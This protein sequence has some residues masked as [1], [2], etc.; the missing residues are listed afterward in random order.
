MNAARRRDVS[1][2]RTSA[3]GAPAA[4]VPT[5]GAPDPVSLDELLST[6]GLLVT[7]GPGGVGKT[8]TAAALAVTAAR[9]GRRVVVVTVDPARRLADALGIDAGSHEPVLVASVTDGSDVTG[10]ELWALMLDAERTFDDLIR[11]EAGDPDRAEA[12]LR[13]PVYRSITGALS[14]AQD[15]MAVER[16]HQ[17]H[18]DGAYDLV[19][20]DT[21]PSRHALDLLEAPDR[22]DGFLGHPVYRALTAPGRAFARVTNAASTA[23]LWTVRKLAGPS[24]VEDTLS[25]FRAISGMEAG[26][27]RRASEVSDL[28]H[29]PSTA[30]VVVSSPRDEAVGESAYLMEGVRDGGFPLGA[31]VVNLVHP[32]ALPLADDSGALADLAPGALA[33]QVAHHADLVALAALERVQIDRLEAM[34]SDVAFVT[35]PLLDDDVHDVGGL[36]AVALAMGLADIAP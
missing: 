29:A 24:I 8:T 1:D 28:L 13:N 27:R 20:V 15:Y 25:F 17:L 16:L 35:V 32:V 19:V 26:L 9:R 12:I 30:F 36:R 2:R 4:A 5:D 6:C 7:C 3:G 34:A 23:F 22:L 10:G 31:V 14:G 18:T 33:D 21:P 11:R